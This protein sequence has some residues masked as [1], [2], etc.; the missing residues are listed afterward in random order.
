[1]FVII[2]AL[3]V[4]VSYVGQNSVYHIVL[5]ENIVVDIVCVMWHYFE[6]CK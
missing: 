5:L 1:M 3:S 4:L 6:E 2:E